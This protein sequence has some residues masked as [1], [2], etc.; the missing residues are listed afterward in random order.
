MELPR[1]AFAGLAAVFLA[2]ALLFASGIV[3][4]LYARIAIEHRFRA[5]SSSVRASAAK[6]AAELQP[7]RA[8]LHSDLAWAFAA[9]GDFEL[10]R[11]NFRT[12]LQRAPANAYLWLEYAQALARARRF[13]E[14]YTLALRQATL[15]SPNA[16][17]VRLVAARMGA[18]HWG[19][20][21]ELE[22]ALWSQNI[23][24]TLRVSPYDLL[25][26]VLRTRREG[27]FC[28]HLGAELGLSRWCFSIQAARQLCDSIAPGA[29]GASV[30]QCRKLGLAISVDEPAAKH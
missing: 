27:S 29:R 14:E 26:G 12:S 13:D 1:W 22:R 19:Q 8:V 6:H 2:V 20:G 30:D 9:R 23:G 16:K 10:A 28:G 18:L 7:W 24:Y 11:Q 25:W 21:G 5:E 3:A 17:P 4:D 15:L